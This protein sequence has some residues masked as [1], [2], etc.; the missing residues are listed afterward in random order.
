MRRRQICFC[1]CISA[2]VIFIGITTRATVPAVVATFEDYPEGFLGTSFTELHS[3]I[4]FTDGVYSRGPNVF[5]IEYGNYTPPNNLPG[6]VGNYLTV[7]ATGPGPGAAMGARAGFTATFPLLTTSVEMDVLYI[8][9]SQP[10]SLTITGFSNTNQQVAQTVYAL[11]ISNFAKVHKIFTSQIPLQKIV[12]SAVGNSVAL[13]YDNISVPE[14]NVILL[15]AFG[16][17]FCAIRRHAR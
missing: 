10:A 14:P 16:V 8:N 11:P 9:P 15:A 13:G 6:I 7:A 17:A 3:G 12:V 4:V 1:A 5:S 2:V